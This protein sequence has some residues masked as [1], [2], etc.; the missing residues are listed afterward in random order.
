MQVLDAVAEQSDDLW[1]RWA[2]LFH[3]VAKPVTKKWDNRIG[4]TFHN[5]NYVGA[6]MIPKIFTLMKL[7]L[8]EHMKFVQKMVELH[9]RPISLVEETVTDSAVRRLL[10]DAGDDIDA[11]MILCDADITSKNADKVRRYRDNFRIV[12]EKL[13]E[14]EEK[15][16][17]RNFQ[18]PITGEE[19]MRI[20]DLT[21][22]RAIGDIKTAI[23][24]AILDGIIPNE[25]EPA[26]QFMIEKAKELGLTPKEA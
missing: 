12:R 25:Y 15:D 3:D 4:W 8:N 13:K 1:L 16:R 19:I 24:D 5:H 18:P 9:M 20:F 10:F 26:Y 17:V 21:P 2:A 11:L 6:K 7:P 23:K 22:C 14:I